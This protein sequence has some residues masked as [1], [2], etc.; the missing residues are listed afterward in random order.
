MLAVAVLQGWGQVA[1]VSTLVLCAMLL[2]I[3]ANLAVHLLVW[4]AA[5]ME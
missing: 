1:A 2:L 5:V 4:Q 3:F